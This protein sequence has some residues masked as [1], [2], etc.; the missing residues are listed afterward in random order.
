LL[1]AGLAGLFLSLH[2]IQFRIQCPLWSE[3]KSTLADGWHLFVS[4]AGISLY[5]NTN[6]FLVGMLAGNVQAGYFSVA[7][8]LIRGM[9][10]LVAPI[11]LAIFPH[12][13]SLA[14]ESSEVALDFIGRTLK[15]LSAITAIFSLILFVFARP[16]ALLF[17]G[18]G[19]LG[20]V[21]IIRWIAPL[22]L[23]ITMNT[24]LGVQTM[25]TL[26]LDKQ[27]SRILILAGIVNAVLAVPLILAFAAQGAGACV[28]IT[29]TAIVLAMGL[30]LR[31]N[32]I[33]FGQKRAE[34]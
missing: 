25:V 19:A 8:K 14:A 33:T 20:S 30:V 29:E 12:V 17:F 34:M 31:R 27:F 22:P 26:G 15:W 5:S 4:T 6:V 2:E 9:A 10:A 32:G 21:P 23:L 24:T 7:E 28:L 1:I 3:V 11:S 16:I 18:H 13:S